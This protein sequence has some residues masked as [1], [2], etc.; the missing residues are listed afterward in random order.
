[1]HPTTE[2]LTRALLAHDA[3]LTACVQAHTCD[4]LTDEDREDLNRA[5]D[6]LEGILKRREVI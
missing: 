3:I 6:L 5:L 4:D 1:M 2:I